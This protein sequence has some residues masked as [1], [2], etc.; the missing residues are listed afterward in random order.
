MT[1]GERIKILRKDREMNQSEF[2]ER[3]GVKYS[4]IGLWE[5]GQRSVSDSAIMLICT[6]F[7]VNENWLRTGKGKMI[8]PV[9]GDIAFEKIWAQIAHSNTE[10]ADFIKRIM[11]A[12]WSLSDEKQAAVKELIEKIAEK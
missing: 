7:G 3:I 12:F 6:K 10:N 2:G 11:R 1:I 4:T 9:G 5:N 8:P